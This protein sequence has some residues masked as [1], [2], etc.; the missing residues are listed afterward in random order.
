MVT[1]LFDID[2]Q[3]SSG[4]NEDDVTLPQLNLAGREPETVNSLEQAYRAWRMDIGT[5]DHTYD[6]SRST[7]QID[8]DKVSFSNSD[9]VVTI[10][11]NDRLLFRESD[12]SFQTYLQLES[13]PAAAGTVVAEHQESWKL[14]LEPGST[15]NTVTVHVAF[16]ASTVRENSRPGNPGNTVELQAETPCTIPCQFDVA[17]TV[18]GVTSDDSSVRLYIEGSPRDEF[19]ANPKDDIL[20]S[21]IYASKEDPISLGNDE[22][23]NK[24]LIGRLVAPTFYNLSLSPAE[25]DARRL[26]AIELL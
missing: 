1:R 23:N 4:V 15:A 12:F 11:P 21:E 10:A 6:L 13:I 22:S 16:T 24:G 26:E 8:D 20:F 7:G 18:L 2:T 5:I 19:R 14:W 17:F 9:Q 3:N 25:V